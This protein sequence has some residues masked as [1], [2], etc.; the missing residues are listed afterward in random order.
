VWAGVIFALS[1][2]P[3][4]ELPSV[5][6]PHSD[7][8][9][10]TLV[11]GVLG[12]LAFRAVRLTSPPER[13]RAV[14]AAAAVAIATL[15]GITDE[16]HQTLTPQRSPDWHDVAADMFGGA[17]GAA[18]MSAVPWMKRLACSMMGRSDE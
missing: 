5:S 8:L 17:L 12:A 18:V 4:Q 15:Y 14:I 6:V 9:A 7:K 3:G 2:V 1:A 11:Y 10:H 16:L 13:S